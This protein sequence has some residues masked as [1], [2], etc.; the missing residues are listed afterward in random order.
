MQCVSVIPETDDD[1]VLE[2]DAC[3]VGIGGVLLVV[4]E[5]L[6]SFRGSSGE[7]IAVIALRRWK[8]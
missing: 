6:N 3:R 1:Y 4:H 2:T 8:D 7:P 5:K